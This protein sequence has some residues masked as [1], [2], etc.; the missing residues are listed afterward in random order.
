MLIGSQSKSRRGMA[1]IPDSFLVCMYWTV[2][3]CLLCCRYWCISPLLSFL[4]LSGLYLY[5][6]QLFFETLSISSSFMLGMLHV[7]IYLASFIW[8][9]K[10]LLRIQTQE[11][12]CGFYSPYCKGR[13]LIT[14][15]DFLDCQEEQNN[16]CGKPFN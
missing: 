6:Y 1:F 10:S 4:L 2:F 13:R 16:R 11:R 8:K 7:T 12:K 9:K 3:S 15:L 14:G 5:F